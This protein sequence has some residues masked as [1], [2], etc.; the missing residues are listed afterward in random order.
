MVGFKQLSLKNRFIVSVAAI[1]VCSLLLALGLV[2]HQNYQIYKNDVSKT[3]DMVADMLAANIAP[4]LLFGDDDAAMDAFVILVENPYVSAAVAYDNSQNVVA[5]YPAGIASRLIEQPE[6]QRSRNIN[7]K[8]FEVIK[9]VMLY[10]NEVGTIRLQFKLDVLYERVQDYSKIFTFSFL[11]SLAFAIFLII[12]IHRFFERPMLMLMETAQQVTEERNYRTRI[13]HTREDEVGTLLN[14]FNNMMQ[15]IED[16]DKQLLEHSENLEQIVEIRTE[17]VSQRANFDA[18]TELPNR[19]LLL[20]RL[21][22]S[23]RGIKRRGG[24]LALLYLDL[25][26]FKIVNDNLG[27]LVGDKLLIAVAK[28]LV[29]ALREED[30]VSRL[31]GDEFVLL[32]ENTHQTEDVENVAKSIIQSLKKPFEVMGHTLHISTSIGIAIYPLDGEDESTLMQHADVSMY[33]AKKSGNGNY[34]FYDPV[35]ELVSRQRLGMETDLRQAMSKDEFMMVFQPVHNIDTDRLAGF[36]ALLRWDRNGEGIITPDQFLPVAEEIGLMKKLEKWVVECVCMFIQSQDRQLIKGLSF[37]INL[38]PGCLRDSEF[39]RSLIDIV[40]EYNVDPRQLEI[41]ITE[42][43]FLEAT[44]AVYIRLNTLKEFGF[45]I[46]IDDFGTGYS[47]L[48]YLRNYPV[49]TLK[50]DGCFISDLEIN[51]SS[52][53]IISST[54]SLGHSLGMTLVAEGVETRQQQEFLHNNHCDLIQGHYYSKP[55]FSD[56]VS[57]YI[58]TNKPGLKVVVNNGS[59]FS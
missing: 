27:H 19:Y 22:Q 2:A 43:T 40:I 25:D 41:E 11:L 55:L 28:R 30:T 53:G 3:A 57:A 9:P 12:M 14:A 1:S 42:E 34:M 6:L 52:R 48:S 4:A 21:K 47:S 31:G 37:S 33:Q 13:K 20:D 44:E 29:N 39:V 36:E 8:F 35:F 45:S 24:N 23:I 58:R 56:D 54:I 46:A 15:V 18:L 7:Q 17:Q 5:D 26:R 50:I 51:K 16:R 59:R 10:G 38:S 32:V 49:D